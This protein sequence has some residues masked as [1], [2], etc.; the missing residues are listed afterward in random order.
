MSLGKKWI[1]EENEEKYR[2]VSN[3]AI[4]SWKVFKGRFVLFIKLWRVCMCILLFFWQQSQKSS[5]PIIFT[6]AT[7]PNYCQVS[8]PLAL[9][10]IRLHLHATSELSLSPCSNFPAFWSPRV[11]EGRTMNERFFVLR[12]HA[13]TDVE[14]KACFSYLPLLTSCSFVFCHKAKVDILP[15]S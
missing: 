13:N 5:S 6:L 11:L 8:L 1:A 12:P 2:W 4:F 9:I 14:L 10:H 3:L 7:H 15:S